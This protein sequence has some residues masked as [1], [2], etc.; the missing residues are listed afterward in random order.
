[1]RA[2][3]RAIRVLPQLQLTELHLQGVIDQEAPD[4]RFADADDELDGLGGL[5]HADDARQHTKHAAFGAA[6]HESGRR[7][8]GIEAA[9]ARA[10]L[11]PEHGCLSFEP[12]DAA[13][14]VRLAGE[15]AGV[16]H[17]VP[18]RKIIGAVED[19]VVLAEQLER[20]LRGQR[21]LVR[22]D[23]HVRIH[24]VDLALGRGELGAAHIVGRVDDLPLQVAEVDDVKVDDAEAPDA[25]RRQV[26]R[27]RRTEAAR[28]DAQDA[29]RLDLALRVHAHLRHDQVPA[30]ALDLVRRQRRQLSLDRGRGSARDRRDDA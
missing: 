9:V 22:L 2:A 5:D 25:G 6:G 20:V 4:Q 28:A 27:G 15:H 14:G 17:E 12:E 26:H 23:L 16:V 19:D 13:V 11:G 18:G 21:R 30:V 1:M 10:V 29:A 8:L 24:R 7:R 3:H